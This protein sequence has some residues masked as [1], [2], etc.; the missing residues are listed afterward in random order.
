MI[1]KQ[2]EEKRLRIIEENKRKAEEEKKRR[3]E[4]KQKLKEEARKK[5]QQAAERK[6]KQEAEREKMEA[7]KAS[8]EAERKKLEAERN[9]ITLESPRDIVVNPDKCHCIL[10]SGPNKGKQCPN[11]KKYPTEKPTYCGNHKGC[12]S[13]IN[14]SVINR[15]GDRTKAELI[16]KSPPIIP[17]K[18]EIKPPVEPEIKPPVEPSIKPKIIPKPV[19]TSIKPPGEQPAKPPVEPLIKPPVETSI[20]PPGE[21][22]AKPKII[23]KPVEPSIK[24]PFEQS[25]PVEPSI[26]PLIA[27]KERPSIKPA[28]P[29]NPNNCQCILI[30]GTREGQQC[31]NPKKYP[32]EKPTYCGLHKLCRAPITESKVIVS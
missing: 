1:S 3:K 17:V 24:P 32:T 2:D 28:T 19:E 30:S 15:P 5:M 22:P 10:G 29:I 8:Q 16:S 18:P 9:I 4:E 14:V 13:P 25:K 20:K 27:F 23:F 21:Q 26:R 6:I 11:S 7:K 12:R 31:S